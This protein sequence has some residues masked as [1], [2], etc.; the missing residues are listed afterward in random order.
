MAG[1]REPISRHWPG[2]RW[3]LLLAV[4]CNA[5]L[6]VAGILGGGTRPWDYKTPAFPL[7]FL[8]CSL[9]IWVVVGL[10]HA[11][12]G[13]PR[14]TALVMLTLTALVAVVDHEKVRLRK[15]PLLP[16]DW[17]FATE[18]GFLVSMV[19]TRFVV[20]LAAGAAAVVAAALLLRLRRRSPYPSPAGQRPAAR[21]LTG[22]VCLLVLVHLGT[23]NAPGNAARWAFEGLGASWMPWSQE[24]NYLG[25]GFVAGFLYNLDIP[26]QPAPPGYGAAEMSRIGERYAAL[27]ERVNRH[28][29]SDVL[30][31]AN[32]LLVLSESL[33]DPLA[34]HGV[35]LAEDP[36]PFVRGLVAGR[37]GGSGGQMLAQSIGGGTANME[38]EALTGMSMA[39][40][41][42]QL[43]VPYQMLVPQYRHFPSVVPWM[44][45]SGH[46]AVALH[47]FTTEMY[48]RREVYDAMGFDAFVHDS[49]MR[50]PRRIG[51]HAYISDA[52]TFA[53]VQR[54]LEGSAAPLFMN[55]VTMQN[56]LP[57]RGRYP[58]P[59][60]ATGPDG[61]AM[62][63]TG[64]YTRGLEHT[65]AALR[66]VLGR[67]RHLDEPTVVVL[68]GD[69]LPGTYPDDV[70]R[71]ND[72]T[73]L[74]RTPYVVWANVPGRR[75]TPDLVSPTH[76]VDLALERLDAAVPPYY[77]LLE[78]LRDEVPA[79]DTGMRYDAGGH[80]VRPG[81][82]SPRAAR[83]LRDYRLV[84]YDLSVGK[85]YS[86]KTMFTLP[87][88][89]AAARGD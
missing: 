46:E 32:V 45:R 53:E 58:D 81:R 30:T 39:G 31:R 26:A 88:G 49:T 50:D 87:V 62:P 69:H 16:S 21:V 24:R 66:A 15:E 56:H 14:A 75:E 10:V 9:V 44:R 19:G 48:R 64:Q 42:P 80:R 82:L 4:A 79:M 2:L 38:F 18:P 70:V 8:L 41:P 85:R 20:A 55:V 52:S 7:L 57:Y 3:T 22:A 83:V 54:R 78:R 71:A 76:F 43:R 74:H 40:F 77:A 25:N 11:V 5:A 65:D 13:R 47:P 63:E 34:L 23:F 68:Y 6:E 28:R 60:E 67:L 1:W 17:E 73:T 12:L 36:I 61:E 33:S 27:A 35:R 72:E 37:H 59:V 86:E 51:H 84:Q 29:D 89:G